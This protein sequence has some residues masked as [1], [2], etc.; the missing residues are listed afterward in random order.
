MRSDAQSAA[1]GGV[2]HRV[3]AVRLA[4]LK[5]RGVIDDDEFRKLKERI[6]EGA[7]V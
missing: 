4:D 3:G 1:L 2:G 7:G 6:V 5:E